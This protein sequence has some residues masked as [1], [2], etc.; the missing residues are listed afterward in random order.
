MDLAGAGDC[1]RQPLAQRESLFGELDRRLQ[2]LLERHRAPSIEQQIPGI[3]HTGNSAGEQTVAVRQLAAV[4]FL[5]P[6]DCRQL[7]GARLGVDRHDLLCFRVIEENH[8]VAA[9]AVGGKVGDRKR[10]LPCDRG[11]EGVAAGLE[12]A[13]RRFGRFRL[14][15]GDRRLPAAN[16][17]SHC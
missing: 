13:P 6:V 16:D 15:R 17:R 9:D 3:D 8:R 10:R 4:V 2:H 5:V 11:V 7:R 14:H 12:N 1:A